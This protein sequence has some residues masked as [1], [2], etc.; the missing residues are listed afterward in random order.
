MQERCYNRCFLFSGFISFHSWLT[1]PIFFSTQVVMPLYFSRFSV[2]RYNG[3]VKIL[4][5]TLITGHDHTCSYPMNCHWFKKQIRTYSRPGERMWEMHTLNKYC[6]PFYYDRAQH[7]IICF[8]RWRAA[9][10]RQLLLWLVAS[11]SIQYVYVK[12]LWKEEESVASCSAG[13]VLLWWG[14]ASKHSA[15]SITALV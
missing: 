4:T 8:R 11:W 6:L 12:L 13:G 3:W 5:G 15:D 14:L 2:S 9:T 10:D 1:R 7:Y